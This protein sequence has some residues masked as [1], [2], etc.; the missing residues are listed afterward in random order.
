V[1]LILAARA[2]TAHD[3][4]NVEITWDTAQATTFGLVP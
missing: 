1:Q 2:R 4:L 3:P